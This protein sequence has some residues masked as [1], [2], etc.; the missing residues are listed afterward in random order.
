MRRIHV[1]YNPVAVTELKEDSS[2]PYGPYRRVG[3]CS[4][5]RVQQFKK[6]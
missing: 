4:G 6:T 5:K 3:H 2:R 1:R